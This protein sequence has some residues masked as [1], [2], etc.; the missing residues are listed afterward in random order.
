MGFFRIRHSRK[1]FNPDST[2]EKKLDLDPT[3]E[4]KLTPD[5][6]STIERKPDTDPTS[7]KN[8]IRIRPSKKTKHV[9]YPI[10]TSKISLQ[11]N[12]NFRLILNH[13]FTTVSGSDQI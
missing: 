10:F 9:S 8:R 2:F 1:N 7:E 13:D 12:Y 5:P 6:D 11:E 3:L 4:K